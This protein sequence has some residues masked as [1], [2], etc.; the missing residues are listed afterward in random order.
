MSLAIPYDRFWGPSYGSVDINV[1]DADPTELVAGV[2][3][4]SIWVLSYVFVADAANAIALEDSDGTV[5]GGPM[6]VAANGGVAAPFNPAG[7]F[8][9]AT[10]KGLYINN[11][12]ADQVGGHLTYIIF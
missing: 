6:S 8:H 2:A 7:H 11:S 4:R 10:G 12:A 3:N 5:L 1:S 9:L